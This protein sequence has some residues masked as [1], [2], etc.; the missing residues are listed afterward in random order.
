[1]QEHVTCLIQVQMKSSCD[2]IG[3][4]APQYIQINNP[5]KCLSARQSILS[6]LKLNLQK[7]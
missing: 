5:L 3:H 2:Q 6:T 4:T 7:L 1:M